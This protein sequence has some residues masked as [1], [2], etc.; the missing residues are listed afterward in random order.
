M[1]GLCICTQCG[2]SLASPQSLWNHKK[3]CA[4]KRSRNADENLVDDLYYSSPECNDDV[5]HPSKVVDPMM[6]ALLNEIVND[7]GI[8][9]PSLGK[10]PPLKKIKLS[11]FENDQVTEGSGI[12][13]QLPPSVNN[14]IISPID[15]PPLS[16]PSES[17]QDCIVDETDEDDDDSEQPSASEIF[18]SLIDSMP[19]TKEDITDWC[20]EED[21]E[22][23]KL[24]TVI[25]KNLYTRFK[26]LH[27]QYLR[28][29]LY[30][31]R[32]DLMFLFN[33]ML[34]RGFIDQNDYEKG[35][36]ALDAEMEEEDS[37]DDDEENIDKE[38]DEM[39]RVIRDV[40]N[41]V[42][43]HDKQELSELLIEIRDEVGEEF[44]DNTSALLL[45]ADK[46][47][48]NE[49]NDDG[50][51]LLP[52][53]EETTLSLEASPVSPSKLLR[54]KI[55]LDDINNNR[56]RIQEIFQRI[57]DAQDNEEDIWKMLVR[58]RLISDEQFEELK[59][60]ENTEIEQ[61]SNVLKGTKIGQGIPFLPTALEG[62]RQ[63]FAK[64]WEDGVKN[65][66]L[67]V[68]KE[69]LRRGGVTIEQF[70]ILLNELEKL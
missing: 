60:L 55:L 66:I 70:M 68:L 38:E 67:P 69:M 47:L 37:S 8:I 45:L 7:G 29:G 2:K 26:V 54:L 24:N 61:I 36:D 12:E 17:E 18:H 20:S 52:L 15:P 48:I 22:D 30:E 6:Q 46:F 11:N 14:E 57:D 5:S 50:K 39:E 28:N 34:R 43:Q 49:F 32:N 62:L 21:E 19:R 64:L 41:H 59:D 35:V 3:R 27:C 51:Q 58:E 13:K 63:K 25:A 56:R 42:I 31:Q 33:E 9:Q 1:K 16:T 23:T 53:I 44:L 40:I 4:K 65:K 10:I